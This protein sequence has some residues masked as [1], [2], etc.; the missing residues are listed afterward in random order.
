MHSYDYSGPYAGFN[1]SLIFARDVA[2]AMTAPAWKL[3]T[4]PW[5]DENKDL[6]SDHHA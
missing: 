1:G 5:E 2:N 4:A 3:M 6:R